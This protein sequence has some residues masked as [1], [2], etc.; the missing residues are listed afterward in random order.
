MQSGNFPSSEKKN[1]SDKLVQ[2]CHGSPGAVACL[3]AASELFKG[4]QLG[5]A[6]L[7]SAKKAGLNIWHNGILKKGFGLCHGISGNGYALLSLYKATSEQVW[8]YRALQFGAI[9]NSKD[10]MAIISTYEF[11]DRY[12]AG[13]SDY[14]YSLM[15]G[16]AGDLCYYMDLIIPK[17]SRQVSEGE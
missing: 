1:P 8:Q 16:A 3:I 7:E 5:D 2:F 11:E 10:Y 9:K 14:P 6:C 17:F 12:I 15:L 13:I 4:E